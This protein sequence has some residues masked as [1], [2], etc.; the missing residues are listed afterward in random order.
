MM[1]CMSDL[2]RKFSMKVMSLTSV[3][4]GLDYFNSLKPI[5]LGQFLAF[6]GKFKNSTLTLDV[7]ND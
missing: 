4:S 2:F 6:D 5:Y 7:E 1:S 3:L